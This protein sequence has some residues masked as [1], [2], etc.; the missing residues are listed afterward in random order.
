MP[1]NGQAVFPSNQV[2]VAMCLGIGVVVAQVVLAASLCFGFPQD[3]AVW[4]KQLLVFVTV[5][6]AGDPPS[7]PLK[8]EIVQ[9]RRLVFFGEF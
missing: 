7:D 4:F 1:G 3:F 9:P 8:S 6:L 5:S 2:G